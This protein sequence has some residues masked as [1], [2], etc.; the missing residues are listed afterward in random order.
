MGKLRVSEGDQV[1]I[2]DT[3]AWKVARRNST[4]GHDQ[5]MLH[6]ELVNTWNSGNGGYTV[7]LAPFS[8]MHLWFWVLWQERKLRVHDSEV[9]RC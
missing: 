3:V 1:W 4:D 7:Q 9:I 8:R 2:L 5:S 6:T